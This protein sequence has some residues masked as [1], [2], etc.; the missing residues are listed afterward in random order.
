MDYGNITLF[1][2]SWEVCNKVGGIYAVVS[3]KALQAVDNFGENYWLLGPDM[4]NNAE[5]EEDNGPAFDPLRKTLEL[6]N[7]KCRVGHWLIPGNPKVI[8]VDFRNK[9]NQNQLLYEYWKAFGVDSMSGGWDYVEPVMFATACGEVIKTVYQH[10]V[11]PVGAPAVAHFHEWMCGAGLL[12]LKRFC[13]TIGTVFTTHATMLGRSMC[14]NG[15]NLDTTG[16][17]SSFNPRQE[18]ANLNITAKCSMETASAREADCFTTVSQI[19]GDE[20]AVVLQKAPDVITPNGLD[21]RVIPD[22]SADR[23]KPGLMRKVILDCAGRLLRRKLPG[24]TRILLISGRYEFVNKGIDVFL[25]ALAQVNKDLADS[26]SHVLAVCAVMGGHSGV[27][28]DA[29]DG[30]PDRKPAGDDYWITSHHVH[31]PSS[32]PIL[33]NCRRLGLDNRPENH[34]QVIFNPALL[35][36]SDGFFNLTYSDLLIGCD[37]G[38]FPSW[39]EPWGYTPEESAAYSVPTITTDLAGFGNWVR[40]NCQR[41]EA[42]NGVIIIDRRHQQR[43]HVVDALRR[44]IETFT[45]L[46]DERRAEVRAAA[47]ATVAQ[48]DWASFFT[49]YLKAYDTAI[50]K[51]LE[52][53]LELKAF[54]SDLNTSFFAAGTSLS[55]MLHTFTSCSPLPKPIARLRE[56]SRNVWWSWNP[57]CW[58]LFIHLAPVVWQSSGHNPIKCLE[59]ADIEVLN[60]A[61]YDP[62]YLGLYEDTMK[63]FDE[64]MARPKAEAEHVTTR[65]PVAYFSTEYGLHESIPIYSGG[66]GILSGD[67]LKS[68]SDLNIPLVAVGLYYRYGYFRQ[69]ID[70][71]GRQVATYVLNDPIDMPVEEVRT[72]TDEPLE[73][74]VQLSDHR[75]FARVWRMRVGTIDLYLLDSDVPKNTA[76]DRK[77]TDHL[78]VADRDFRIR[79]EILLGIGGVVLL[80]KLGIKPSVYHMNEGHSAFL[81]LR[82]IRDVMK[83]TKLSF[84]EA[85]EIVRGSCVFTTHTP[86]DAGN[87]RFSCDL[88]S[89]YFGRYIAAFDMSMEQFLALGQGERGAGSAFEMT[90]L[91]LRNSYRANGVSRLHGDVSRHMWQSLWSGVP[92]A[93]VPIGHVTNGVHM[94]SYAGLEMGEVIRHVLGRNWTD[95]EAGSRTWFKFDSIPDKVLWRVHNMQKATLIEQ[96]RKSTPELFRKLGVD[97]Q[98][99]KDALDKLDTDVILIGFARRFA[100]YKRANLLF[101]D[102]KRLETI[103]NDSKHP[104]A[105]LFAGKAHPADNQGIDI[106]QQIIRY[107]TDKRFLGRIFFL[108][109]YSLAISRLMVQGCDVWLNTP[110]RPYEASGTSGQKVTV[111]GVLNLS[112]SDGWWCEGYNGENGWTIGPVKTTVT[113]NDTQ[114]DYSDAEALYT[115][116]EEQVVPLYYFRNQDNMPVRWVKTMKESMRS[117]IA[118]YSSHRMVRDYMN[119]YYEPTARRQSGLRNDNFAIIR[120]LVAWKKDLPARFNTIHTGLLRIDGMDGDIC[121]CGQSIYVTLSFNPGQMKREELV[122]QLAIGPF[123]GTGFKDKPVTEE[124]EYERT[125]SDGSLVYSCHHIIKCSGHQAYGVRI[126]PT[127]PGLGCIFDTN[128]VLWV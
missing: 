65:H 63:L 22:Y 11:E 58:E 64:Y 103:L 106:M 54:A 69:Q 75:L 114:N 91:A 81:I 76:E 79:Q 78:Y 56:L 52:A 17:D 117:L 97:R 7:L 9:Y 68:S 99:I 110:R 59:S 96:I 123:D 82:L 28:A 35:D 90:I 43:E 4:G 38:V 21:L 25:E 6:H 33:T 88:M 24:D 39:Y 16:L 124:L 13:P 67:H 47:R 19:T 95:L 112:I 101:A 121:E 34:V 53:G 8:L 120:S 70:K 102:L 92:T 87:E 44:S 125:T 3:S 36:G 57:S 46:S 127:A 45:S 113:P 12:Y 109:D 80:N 15:R 26:Q 1:E 73:I 100:P 93:E 29:I 49:Y 5:F 10:F 40:V 2:T 84:A 50:A 89:R 37:G 108:E 30:D 128:L 18:A 83:E 126:M 31:N 77:V 55:P 86:V 116:L 61:A 48:C 94:A 71:E 111:N 107:C 60:Q 118:V 23:L 85:R 41:D 14:G 98:S 62:A 72:P 27:N 42:A 20:A 51:A 115:L 104:V 119:G 122:V 32:D 105:L 74:S 66:L